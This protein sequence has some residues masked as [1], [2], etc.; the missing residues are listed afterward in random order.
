MWLSPP[1]HWMSSA[2]KPSNS[3]A[4]T[5]GSGPLNHRPPSPLTRMAYSRQL[6]VMAVTRLDP[7]TPPAASASTLAAA[8]EQRR[9]K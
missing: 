2:V 9:K 8:M 1:I 6:I 4:S 7:A 3:L 5:V